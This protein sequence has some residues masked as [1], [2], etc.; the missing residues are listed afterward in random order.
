MVGTLLRSIHDYYYYF[1]FFF[2]GVCVNLMCILK[3]NIVWN[4][5]SNLDQKWQNH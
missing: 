2:G 3:E 4:F 1:F 5:Y